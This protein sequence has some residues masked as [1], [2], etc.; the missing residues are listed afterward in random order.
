M[1]IERIKSNGKDKPK[2]TKDEI[3]TILVDAKT[4]DLVKYINAKK[5]FDA[6]EAT[7]NE[8]APAIRKLGATHIF[9]SNVD[10]HGIGDVTKSIK[11]QTKPAADSKPEDIGTVRVTVQDKVAKFNDVAAE[12]LFDTTLGADANEFLFETRKAKFNS[13]AFLKKTED[14]TEFNQRAYDLFFAACDAVAKKLGI[15]NP[16]STDKVVTVKPEF[17]TARYSRFG[18]D[19]QMK[20]YEVIPNTTTITPIVS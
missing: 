1:P 14:G 17:F 4:V 20:I 12:E 3:L 2:S 15:E 5:A 6:A 8:L 19:E 9:K 7:V 18:A 16:L 13:D 11:L 10:S